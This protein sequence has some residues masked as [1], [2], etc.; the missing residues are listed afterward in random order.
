MPV[1]SW[2]DYSFLEE[3]EH[4]D[5]DGKMNRNNNLGLPLAHHEAEVLSTYSPPCVHPLPIP[6]EW[7]RNMDGTPLLDHNGNPVSVN[8]LL[9]TKPLKPE[10]CSRPG[11]GGK[12]LTYLSGE[13]VTRTLNEI[14]GY[15]GW[16]LDIKETKREVSGL[17]PRTDNH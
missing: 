9:A 3:N 16:N 10:L 7:V 11:P 12:K 17:T 5:D 8:Q 2:L 1:I 15:D 6:V 14:F 13:G 4:C